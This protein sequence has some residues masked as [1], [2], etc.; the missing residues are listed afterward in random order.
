[1]ATLTIP[2]QSLSDDALAGII[3]EFVTRE[4][5]EYGAAEV[6]LE[7]KYRQVRDQLAAGEA[8][9]TFDDEVQTCSIVSRSDLA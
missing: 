1:M 2:W 3:E 4:G 7:R 5:T 6:S 9:I 8:I